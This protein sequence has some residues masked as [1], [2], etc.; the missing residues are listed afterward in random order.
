MPFRFSKTEIDGV[1]LIQPEVF[2]DHRGF[3]METYK[4]SDFAA[5]GLAEP[6][7]QENHSRSRAGTLRGLHYQIEPKAQGK[8]VRVVSGE[9]YDVAVD[10][11]PESATYGKWIGYNLSAENRISLYIPRGCAHGF[12]V[13]RSDAEVIYKMTDEYAP[14]YERGIPWNDRGLNI[15]W[16]IKDPI[17]SERDSKWPPFAWMR[18]SESIR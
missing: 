8:L 12:C 13:V 3:F 4:G 17:I 2:A 15:T 11:R 5:A 7:I 10:V 18:S 16:P 14:A 6:F 9:I 1:V